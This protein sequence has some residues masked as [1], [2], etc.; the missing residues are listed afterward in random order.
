MAPTAAMLILGYQ[1]NRRSSSQNCLSPPHSP[2]PLPPRLPT[3][4]VFQVKATAAVKWVSDHNPIIF[5]QERRSE[6]RKSMVDDDDA[7]SSSSSDSAMESRFQQDLLVF[8]CW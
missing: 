6:A 5:S 8:S 4:T 3:A 2:P 1:N 7:C